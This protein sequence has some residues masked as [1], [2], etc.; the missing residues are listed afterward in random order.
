MVFEPNFTK[1]VSSA[2]KNIGMTQS[3][4]ELNLP[5]NEDVINAI[6]SISAKSAIVSSE[7]VG[8]TIN[9][10]GLVDFQAMYE[11][12]GIS[13][14]DYSAEFKD[15]FTYTEDI[16]GEVV[17][18][19]NVVDVNSNIVSNGIKVVAI[20]EVTIDEITTKD[21]NILTNVEGENICTS[22]KKIELSSY[23]GKATEKYD[24]TQE[25]EIK[26]AIKVLMVTPSVCLNNVVPNENYL[27]VN[28]V[29]NV[30]VCYQIGE[31]N[32]D[33]KNIAKSFDFNFDVALTGI[34]E[35]S[36]IQ[37]IISL[38]SNE[39]KVSTILEEDNSTISLYIPIIYTG[40]VF[41]KSMLDVV[42][43]VY[44]K[45]NYL[46]ITSENFDTIDGV[47][48][49]NFKDAISGT[50]SILDTAP[51][52]DDILGVCTNNIVLASSRVENGIL[53]IEGVANATVVYY[54]K[55]TNSITSVQV[56]MP[57]SV[58]QKIEGEISNVVTLCL[59]N[60]NAR[61]KRGKEI[62]VSADLS[63]Y[64]DM[65]R[66]NDV[67]VI[68]NISLGDE[69]PQDD[70]ALYIYIVKPNETVWDIAKDMN[71]SQEL[72]LEQNP[73]IELPLK[74]GEKIVIYKPNLIGFD[75]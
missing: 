23:L 49:I 36:Y 34:E 4:I 71:V 74:G 54:T 56:E 13:A 28:G 41:T 70:C 27:T 19:S 69:K 50:A 55:E 29:L 68:S 58:E 46:S 48:S 7:V 17:L 32:Y 52:I 12:N 22:S 1:V 38:I 60:V 9:F 51:F 73:E 20:I 75:K 63:V 14:I 39:I 45:T 61:S 3:V 24:F 72:I 59:A 25:F 18:S 40:Y 31:N 53:N 5:T 2:R 47:Q 8:N 57:F 15:K 21:V 6:Y 11:S 26:D 62:E 37:S 42:D 67:C 64:S 33:I 30:D 43:D 16:N 65:Y 10:V 66:L 35:T 44:S